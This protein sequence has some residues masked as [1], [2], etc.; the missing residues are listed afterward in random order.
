MRTVRP[1]RPIRPPEW[2]VQSAAEVGGL[3]VAL[4]RSGVW[5]SVGPSQ[6]VGIERALRTWGQS[7][8]ALGV[9]A[10][11]RYPDRAAVI[12]EH[13]SITYAELDRRCE[14]IA[15]GFHD[16]HGIV[17]GSKVAVLCRNHRGFLE[18]TLAASRI[19]ADV[20]F[21]NT[22]FARP[23]VQAVLE[24]HRPDLLVHD[25]EFTPP[26]G[27]P[28]VLSDLDDVATSTAPAAPAPDSPGQI[29]ILTSGTTGTPKAA[30]RVPTAL[31]WPG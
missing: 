5:R 9:I 28:A 6:L 16:A 8:A 29:T 26:D 4:I 19:G 24:R 3:S 10:A 30:P 31:G 17:A 12:E 7:M 2:L 25:T 20:L 13:G 14:R 21:V 15:A 18:A 11:I 22:E 27:V 23:Q 1:I